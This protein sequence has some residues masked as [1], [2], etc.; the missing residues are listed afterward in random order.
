ALPD[1]LQREAHPPGA[2]VLDERHAEPSLERPPG[3]ADVHTQG[4][5]VGVAPAALG[6]ALDSLH[7]RAHH[8]GHLV[9]V[10][11]RPAAQAGPVPGV[12]RG[13]RRGEELAV[14]EPRLAGRARGPAEHARRAHAHVEDALVLGVAGKQGLVVTAGDG[15]RH[16]LECRTRRARAPPRNEQVIPA[17]RA[18]DPDAGRRRFRA[19]P[20]PTRSPTALPAAARFGPSA[21]A[22]PRSAA[23]SRSSRTAFGP[24]PCRASSSASDRLTAADSVSMPAARSALLAGRLR[25][26]GRPS[27]PAGTMPEAARSRGAT[28]RFGAR[29]RHAFSSRALSSMPS[30][31]AR[32]TR[33]PI[34]WPER[35]SGSAT[36]S[37]SSTRSASSSVIGS[38]TRPSFVS[39]T[40]RLP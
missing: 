14:L 40:K 34:S 12:E 11:Q 21:A 6:L 3:R 17:D 24:T 8:R 2:R 16:G 23:A 27:G 7:Q 5:E 36:A 37:R 1:H 33:T 31:S 25:P 29:L 18:G 19:A 15:L 22:H 38:S 4:A 28:S 10:R 9:R 26:G 30:T 35:V 20:P 32:G 39:D 13:L